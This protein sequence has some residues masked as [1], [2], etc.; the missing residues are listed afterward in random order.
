MASCPL[1]GVKICDCD[2][3]PGGSRLTSSLLATCSFYNHVLHLWKW[4]T[5]ELGKTLLGFQDG[6]DNFTNKT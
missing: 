3:D 2:Q 1:Q 4:R 5:S 6:K